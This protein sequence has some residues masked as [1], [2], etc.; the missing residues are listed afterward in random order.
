MGFGRPWIGT[1]F[2]SPCWHRTSPKLIEPSS[3]DFLLILGGICAF[4]ALGPTSNR[5]FTEQHGANPL[6]AFWMNKTRTRRSLIDY[7][8]L[9]YAPSSANDTSCS[10]VVRARLHNLIRFL[11]YQI[12]LFLAELQLVIYLQAKH[13]FTSDV[14][15]TTVCSLPLCG[16]VIRPFGYFYSTLIADPDLVNHFVISI[17]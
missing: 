10:D 15:L 2:T 3:N 14:V 5:I 7:S 13:Y 17:A 6:S 9:D 16:C 11:H 1:D 8:I 4:H 12:F